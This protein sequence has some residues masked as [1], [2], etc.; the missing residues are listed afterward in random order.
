MKNMKTTLQYENTDVKFD[1]L[2]KTCRIPISLN[3]AQIAF[4]NL[5]FDFQHNPIYERQLDRI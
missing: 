5:I 3:S 2:R 4:F 1:S